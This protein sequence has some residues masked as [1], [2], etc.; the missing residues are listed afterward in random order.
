MDNHVNVR[1]LY[2][3]NWSRWEQKDALKFVQGK[4]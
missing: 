4:E 1:R 2:P 3:V